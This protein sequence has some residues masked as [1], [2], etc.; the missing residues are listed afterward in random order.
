MNIY[1]SIYDLINQYVFS[2]AIEPSSVQD[3]AT[4][5]ISLGAC[6]FMISL[7]F[8]LVWRIIKILCS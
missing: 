7:P 8:I 4:T 2:N 5:L 1:Q 3:L 6:I